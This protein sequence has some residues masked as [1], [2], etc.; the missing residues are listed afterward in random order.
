VA[1]PEHV[2]KSE[3]VHRLDDST[4]ISLSE[5]RR[6]DLPF[7]L[8]VRNRCR[9]MLHDDHEFSLR[10]AEQWFDSTRP[11]FYL[12]ALDCCPIG[13]FRTSNW[14]EVN[15]HVYVGCDLHESHRG[16]GYARVAYDVFMKYLF[17]NCGIN[18]VSLE[19]L[20]HNDRARK[21]YQQLGFV[22][23]GVK[24]QEVWRDGRYLDSLMFSMLKSEFAAQYLTEV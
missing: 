15:R 20:S 22:L 13:Y 19:V 7:L 18:K 8:D 14:D 1:P 12:V 17:N 6:I 4:I 21:L 24:R 2:V 11:R 10:E 16:K 3:L 5:L 23:E 9:A